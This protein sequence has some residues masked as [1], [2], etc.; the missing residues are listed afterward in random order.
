MRTS[1]T[2]AFFLIGM[3]FPAIADPLDKA[4]TFR[5]SFDKGLE[6]EVALGDSIGKFLGKDV[7]PRFTKG[8][9]GQGFLT[10]KENQAAQFAAKDNV[11]EEEGSV[12][13]WMK[14]LPGVTW[15]KADKLH[16]SFFY[17]NGRNGNLIFYK[18][19]EHSNT[20]LFSEVHTPENQRQVSM[21]S[22]PRY[23]EDEWHFYTFT[24]KGEKMSLFLDAEL[25]SAKEDFLFPSISDKSMFFIGQCMGAGE[26]N[27][28]VDEF[29]IY[30]QAL[31]EQDL[32]AIYKACR[33]LTESPQTK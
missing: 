18:Y 5:L 8:L 7:E 28:V 29:T 30:N 16:Y 13:F 26:E 20:C 12:V 2:V 4:V 22:L 14:G 10:G 11:P 27:R 17:L 23:T 15:N 9:K 32:A 21:I 1:I 24:W 33:S 19:F 31:S 3:S 6:P 25:E